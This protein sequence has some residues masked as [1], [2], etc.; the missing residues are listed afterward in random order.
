MSQEEMEIGSC[1]HA[2]TNRHLKSRISRLEIMLAKEQQLRMASSPFTTSP[3]T[4][5]N[6]V[7]RYTLPI[8]PTTTD[9]YKQIVAELSHEKQVKAD[10]MANLKAATTE[11]DAVRASLEKELQEVKSSRDVLLVE[12]EELQDE[13]SNIKGMLKSHLK[14][15]DDVRHDNRALSHGG[16]A[17]DPTN[18]I[19]S[20][21]RLT[22]LS[23]KSLVYQIEHASDERSRLLL[24]SLAENCP[25]FHVDDT[26]DAEQELESNLKMH[27]AT[28]ASR[29]IS[30]ETLGLLSETAVSH[31]Y[32]SALHPPLDILCKYIVDLLKKTKEELSNHAILVRQVLYQDVP[33]VLQDLF[34][35][36]NRA[37]SFTFPTEREQFDEASKAEFV[38]YL[39]AQRAAVSHTIR[40][41]I[42]SHLKSRQKISYRAFSPGD[43]ALFLP[44]RNANSSAWAAFNVGAPHYF[45]DMKG[46]NTDG[47]DFML[48][49]IQEIKEN[50]GEPGV[51]DTTSSFES[52]VAGKSTDSRK[53]WEVKILEKKKAAVT[54]E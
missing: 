35:L 31:G 1:T 50:H 16:F 36:L 25:E 23:L 7:P 38:A 48:G 6:Y 18:S 2:Q 8:D 53:W 29:A 3:S 4:S 42:A 32:V 13:Y 49:R 51:E 20:E 40:K 10:L 12:S 15:Q 21:S 9:A 26:A 24:R 34:T 17:V 46:I 52:G 5:P 19:E 37:T 39:N 27:I 43:L 11:H 54:G 41:Y 30:T 45:L 22:A 44:T 14:S 33:T 47:R 28:L